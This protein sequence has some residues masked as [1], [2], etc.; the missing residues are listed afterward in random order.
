[1]VA[2]QLDDELDGVDAGSNEKAMD[3]AN[4]E[5]EGDKEFTGDD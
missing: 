5:D 1:L 2:A 4:E 3:E